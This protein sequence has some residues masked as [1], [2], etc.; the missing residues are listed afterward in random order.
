MSLSYVW[1][2]LDDT[3][4]FQSTVSH[5]R[6]PKASSMPCCTSETT[7]ERSLSI[8]ALCINQVDKQEKAA[9]ILQMRH[10]YQL[11]HTTIVW[12]GLPQRDSD[13]ILQFYDKQSHATSTHTYNSIKGCNVLRIVSS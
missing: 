8:V 11:A 7:P 12:L 2:N 10:I 13:A 6:L 3:I 9:Q 4:L 1:G 5:F